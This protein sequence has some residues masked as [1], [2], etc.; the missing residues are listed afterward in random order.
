MRSGARMRGL[1]E[2]L[3]GKGI[4]V[5]CPDF[6]HSRPWHGGHGENARDLAELAKML[7][8]GRRVALAGFSAGGCAALLATKSF[9]PAALVLLDPVLVGPEARA[10]A[11]ACNAP[12]LALFARPGSCNANGSGRATA[13]ALPKAKLIDLP[14]ASHAHFEFPL[15]PLARALC[16]GA[17]KGETDAALQR[18]I[19]S[20]VTDFLRPHLLPANP[21]K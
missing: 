15:D 8:T 1:A 4:A 13:Q 20:E 19:R 10:A 7:G 16:G 6:R 9:K 18:R 21:R 5:A 2:H 3:G 12:A 11:V 14:G 17:A